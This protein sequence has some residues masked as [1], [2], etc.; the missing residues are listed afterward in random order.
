MS[1]VGFVRSLAI[2][3]G[4]IIMASCSGA[5]LSGP[6][7][8]RETLTAPV[9]EASKLDLRAVWWKTQYKDVIKVSQII[10]QSGGTISIPETG[11]TLSFPGGAVV[12]PI[13][14][15]VTADPQ[16]VAY[17]MEPTGTQFLKG[18]TATQLLNTTTLSGSP[19][20]SQLYAAYIADDSLNLSGKVPVLEVEPGTTIFSVLSPLLPQAHVW[21]RTH[22][23][24]YMLASG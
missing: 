21:T 14:I 12:A 16:Y 15:T 20:R 4:A 5:A 7:T 23:S 2:F 3:A 10:D 8:D 18:V 19:L 22:F 11:L 13:T 9:T 17:K 1:R 24:R 6:N